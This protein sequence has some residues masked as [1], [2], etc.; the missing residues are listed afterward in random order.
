M[1]YVFGRW[2]RL[3]FSRE[4]MQLV[5]EGKIV[6]SGKH[7]PRTHLGPEQAPEEAYFALQI[8]K[9]QLS[10][11]SPKRAERVVPPEFSGP[12]ELLEQY[13]PGDYV[14]IT[15]TTATGRQIQQIERLGET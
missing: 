1:V 3:F 13:S 4:N 12:V 6:E 15:A 8:S 7:Q 2:L 9:A 5:V 14:R 10:D 11:G